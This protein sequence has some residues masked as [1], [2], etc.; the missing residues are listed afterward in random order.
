MANDNL[1]SRTIRREQKLST[2][3]MRADQFAIAACFCS[4][5]KGGG[6]AW[7][8]CPERSSQIAAMRSGRPYAAQSLR[9]YLPNYRR[10]ED[11]HDFDRLC[12]DPTFKLA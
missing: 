12:C 8:G 1:P 2:S 10:Y 3:A 7:T 11:G 9:A 5:P 4:R 6:S